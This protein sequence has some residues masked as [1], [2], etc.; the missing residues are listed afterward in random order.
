MSKYVRIDVS[1]IVST[2]FYIEVEDDA[3]DDEIKALATNEITL[4]HLYPSY[5]DDWLQ[6]RLNVRVYG[7]DGMLKSW[8]SDQLKFLIDGR[9]CA[10]S[11]G[12]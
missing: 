10:T 8:N 3:T 12:E 6:K 5:I 1:T 7:I 11:E 2:D 4:P 9:D